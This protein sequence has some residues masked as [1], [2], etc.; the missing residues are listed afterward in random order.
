MLLDDRV[1]AAP[2]WTAIL[3]VKPL[4]SAKSRLGH[5]RPGDLALAFLLDVVAA[6]QST[7]SVAD[8]IVVTSDGDVAAAAAAVDARVVDDSEHPGINAAAAWAAGQRRHPGGAVVLVSDLPCLT[9][10]SCALALALAREHRTSFLPDAEGTGT[11]MWCATEGREVRTSFGVGSRRA[12][13]SAGAVDLVE[14][15][16]QAAAGLVPARRDVDTPD[17]LAAAIALGVGANS[18]RLVT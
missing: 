4:P 16:P 10:E 17:D 2:G 15:H 18:L 7:P 13:A 1:T 11:T 6:L 9:A 5:A 3:P 12:H 14:H 8:I